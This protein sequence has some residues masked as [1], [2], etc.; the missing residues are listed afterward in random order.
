MVTTAT[1]VRV[2][3]A[4]ALSCEGD[5]AMSQGPATNEE[6]RVPSDVYGKLAAAA[7]EVRREIV[8][9]LIREHPEGRLVLP[10]RDG[11][12]AMLDGIALPRPAPG[13]GADRAPGPGPRWREGRSGLHLRRADL[14]GASLRAADLRGVDMEEADLRE[15]DLDGADIRGADRK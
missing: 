7:P 5:E 13:P 3:A 4:E 10:G 8:L 11:V 15:A 14:R 12:R 2:R 6:S 9:R 1:P